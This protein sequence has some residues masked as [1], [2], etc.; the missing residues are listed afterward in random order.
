MCS[1]YPEQLQLVAPDLYIERKEIKAVY[2]DA[3]A[4]MAAYTD[5]ECM[6]REISVSDY[7]MLKDISEISTQEAVDS[8]IDAYTEQLIEE[9]L[10]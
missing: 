5:Y 4:E 2:H 7:N 6:S 10:L 1:E 3:T 9:G 8:A